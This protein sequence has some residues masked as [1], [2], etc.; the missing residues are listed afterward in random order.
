MAEDTRLRDDL[1]R[2]R[3]VMANERTLLSYGRTAL[4]LVGVAVVIFH[5]A[6]PQIALIAGAASLVFAL[7]VFFW[8]LNSYRITA[9]KLKAG[10]P[11]RELALSPVEND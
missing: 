4:G 2:E 11:S 9:A 1:A 10:I 8:G 6:D 7:I 3:T 5:F